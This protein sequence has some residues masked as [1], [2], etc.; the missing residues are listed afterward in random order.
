MLEALFD[1]QAKH[2]YADCMKKSQ[3]QYT[4][5]QVPAQVDLALR[6]TAHK[7]RVS[8]NQAA[9]AALAR[10]LGLSDRR[11]VSDDLDELAGTWEE[12]ATFDAVIDE[13]DRVDPEQ[14]S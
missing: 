4:L 10:G 11:V 7:E 2:A 5:R 12:D 9:L 8:I 13:H 14:W 3:I 1:V 6:E